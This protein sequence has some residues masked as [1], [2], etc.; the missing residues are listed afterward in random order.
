MKKAGKMRKKV[1]KKRKMCEN[2]RKKS[3]KF[4]KMRTNSH[5]RR[6]AMLN[7]VETR[8]QSKR[9]GRSLLSEHIGE[10]K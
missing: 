9:K 3:E 6:L 8:R 7:R 10:V 1:E 2:V 4:T 5:E